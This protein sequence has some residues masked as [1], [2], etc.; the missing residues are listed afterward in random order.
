[1]ARLL[2]APTRIYVRAILA[3]LESTPIHAMAHITGGGLLENI[4]RVIPEGFRAHIK[5]SAWPQPAVFSWLQ[6]QGN[7]ADKEMLRT[8]NCGI[9][10]VLC[11]D[12]RYEKSCLAHFEKYAIDAWTIGQITEHA[13]GGIDFQT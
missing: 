8:F 4:P 2:L 13:Q 11:V 7:I 6:Q 9:G 3:L 10:M 12:P 5:R 1:M